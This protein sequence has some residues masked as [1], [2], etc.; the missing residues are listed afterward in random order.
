MKDITSGKEFN[1]RRATDHKVNRASLRLSR[2]SQLTNAF[3]CGFSAGV[4][5]IRRGDRQEKPVERKNEPL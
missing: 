5:A 1:D 2:V 3:P 4:L